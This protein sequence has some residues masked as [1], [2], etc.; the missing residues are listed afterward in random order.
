ML[1]IRPIHG[2][3]LV[4]DIPVPMEDTSPGGLIVTPVNTEPKVRF[5]KVARLGSG[6]DKNGLKV[7]HE[8]KV[9]DVVVFGKFMGNQFEDASMHRTSSRLV[10]EDQIFCRVEELPEDL[11]DLYRMIK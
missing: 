4:E 7:I 6:V 9:G 11:S 5:G 2:Y 3:I 1:K 10:S 8:T